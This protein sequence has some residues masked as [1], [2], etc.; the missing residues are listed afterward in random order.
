EDL[1]L[2]MSPLLAA[3]P[4]ASSE[5]S[6]ESSLPNWLAASPATLE[7][8]ADIAP[9]W[10]SDRPMRGGTRLL[11]LQARCP[12]RAF[13]E[14]RLGAAALPEP[15]PGVAAPLRGRILHRALELLWQG[16][17]GR[18]ALEALSEEERER[19]VEHSARRALEELGSAVSP[20]APP[21]LLAR[22]QLRTQ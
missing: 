18:A 20:C 13:A 3:L 14:M 4:R 12:F 5:V 10:T 8:V 17:S 7:T 21:R 22:E 9:R 11:E 2:A 6:L 19:R 1:P 15:K 16:L